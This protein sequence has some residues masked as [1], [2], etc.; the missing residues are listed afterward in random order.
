MHFTGAIRCL[1]KIYSKYILKVTS[2]LVVHCLAEMIDFILFLR[3]RSCIYIHFSTKH[4]A[5]KCC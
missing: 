4:S 1:Q 3:G 5:L 2:I